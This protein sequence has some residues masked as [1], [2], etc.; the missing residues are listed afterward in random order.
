MASS[1][2]TS[3]GCTRPATTRAILITSGYSILVHPPHSLVSC[4]DRLASLRRNLT[5]GHLRTESVAV[6][7]LLSHGSHGAAATKR[8][9]V[10]IQVLADAGISSPVTT[11]CAPLLVVRV[12]PSQTCRRH[13]ATASVS[14]IMGGAFD[15]VRIFRGRGRG[16]GFASA[17]IP[18]A[19]GALGRLSTV[20]L[21]AAVPPGTP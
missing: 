15:S 8:R 1:A 14:D 16:V 20:G 2:C 9:P 11:N 10:Q 18:A 7:G 21:L 5:L 4:P 6:V 17:T 13:T 12:A 3:S 19:S